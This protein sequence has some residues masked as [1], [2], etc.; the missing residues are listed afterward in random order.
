ME[1]SRCR[2]RARSVLLYM[3]FKRAS[4]LRRRMAT[5]TP[6]RTARISSLYRAG[7]GWAVTIC[8]ECARAPAS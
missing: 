6:F 1:H 5:S 3:P 4:A 2:H 8:M 7:G